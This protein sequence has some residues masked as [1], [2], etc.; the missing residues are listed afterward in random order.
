ML[1]INRGCLGSGA[2]F[3][4]PAA[5]SWSV[6]EETRAT[7]SF[8]C[9]RVDALPVFEQRRRLGRQRSCTE[10]VIPGHEHEPA[11]FAMCGAR[12]LPVQCQP[13]TGLGDYRCDGLV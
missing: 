5:S 8:S 11:H 2:M 12:D 13:D 1:G 9:V 10:R 3:G 7:I 6:T 4:H